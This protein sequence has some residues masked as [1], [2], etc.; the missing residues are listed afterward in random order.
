MII[1]YIRITDQ[2]L[3]HSDH[4]RPSSLRTDQSALKQDCRGQKILLALAAV[5][6]VSAVEDLG[7]GEAPA[8]VVVAVVLARVVE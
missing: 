8:A 5:V 1:L 7:L 3:R 6:G 4:Q 2:A